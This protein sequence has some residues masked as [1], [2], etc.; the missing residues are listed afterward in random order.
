MKGTRATIQRLKGDAKGFTLLETMIGLL[1]FSVGIL[2]MAALQTTS[3]NSNTLAEDVQQNT[4]EA[5]AAIEELMAT[6][7]LDQR[8]D[9]D[10]GEHPYTTPDGK[11]NIVIRPLNDEAIPGA[12]RVIVESRF[13]PPGGGEQSITLKIFKPDIK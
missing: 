4:V 12:K 11:Y 10:G 1:V 13:T 5:V 8:F 6:D 2:G 9:D 3:V 7:Y